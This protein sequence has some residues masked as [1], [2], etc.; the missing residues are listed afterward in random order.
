MSAFMNTANLKALIVCL[1]VIS[2]TRT[3]AAEVAIRV[4]ARPKG[5]P[6]EAY[7][8]ATDGSSA[9][10]G[11]VADDFAVTLD[12]APIGPVELTLPPRQDPTQ[13]L[14]VV[15]I[16]GIWTNVEPFERLIRQLEPGDFVAVVRLW[17]GRRGELLR[18]GEVSVLRFRQIDGGAH[19]E[20]IVTFLNSGQSS[21]ARIFDVPWP[22]LRERG[23]HYALEQFENH[24]L[25]LPNGPRAIV[26]WDVSTVGLEEIVTRANQNDVAIFTRHFAGRRAIAEIYAAQQTLADNTGGVL[27]QVPPHSGSA[28]PVV[29]SWLKDGYRLTIP[30]AAVDDCNLHMLEVTVDGVASSAPF[31]RCDSISEP[32]EFPPQGEVEPGSTVTSAARRVRGIGSPAPVSV[33]RGQYS[34]GCSQS[35]TSEPGYIQPGEAI[36]VRHTAAS[37]PGARSITQLIIG[38]VSSAFES[39]VAP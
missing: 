5:H 2:I 39:Y 31:S 26:S 36:C 32:I 11:L 22:Q 10:P 37:Q 8:L 34:I 23:I 19:T 16:V 29:A 12:G 7:V 21:V 13:K 14:S 24:A 9:I 35:F 4:D 3:A 15:F 27:V 30:A 20:Q 38:G 1:A 18:A 33:F 25:R 17:V 6:I 28:V